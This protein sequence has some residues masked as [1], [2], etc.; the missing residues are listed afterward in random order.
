MARFTTSDGVAIAYDF[1][2]SARGDHPPVV[3][4]HGFAVT[5]QLTWG[6]TGVTDGLADAPDDPARYGE[7]RMACDVRELVDALGF[8]AFDLVGYS[9]GA[10]AALLVAADDDRVR[11]LV[12]GGV[13]A[14]V[15]EVGGQDHRLLPPDL[16]VEAFL[17]E[18][19]ALIEHTLG[20]AW[21]AFATT[22]DANLPALAAQTRAMHGG[23]VALD[24][25]C[26]D[27]LVLVADGDN[28]AARPELLAQAIAGASVQRISRCDHLG[29]P[30]RP[31]F[32]A[33]LVAF[34]NAD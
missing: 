29:A 30:A 28:L 9:M 25:I 4:L 32:L 13:G 7:A 21:R 23:G 22:L 20:Q 24:R 14:G 1:D 33:A 26:A 31:E 5:S 16:L 17:A 10:V 6:A 12:V 2:D 27:A 3:L 18:D 34:L 8:A 15:V 11:R 19:P